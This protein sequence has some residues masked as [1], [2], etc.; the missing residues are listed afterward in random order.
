MKKE[1]TDALKIEAWFLRTWEFVFVEIGL[2]V[3]ED[4]SKFRESPTKPEFRVRVVVNVV[5][6]FFRF[7]ET[8]TL[9]MTVNS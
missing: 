9:D 4:P 2:C 7:K 8:R 1:P 5:V 6:F 3:C